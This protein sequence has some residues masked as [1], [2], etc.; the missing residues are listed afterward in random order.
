MS[1]RYTIS[2]VTVQG[3]ALDYKALSSQCSINHLWSPFF[4]SSCLSLSGIV[5]PS[6]HHCLH[7]IHC[8]ST[9][10]QSSLIQINFI[11]IISICLSIQI[12]SDCSY[13]TGISLILTLL[14]CST[15]IGPWDESIL[16]SPITNCSTWAFAYRSAPPPFHYLQCAARLYTVHITWMRGSTKRQVASQSLCKVTTL[17][18]VYK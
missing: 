18:F 6:L 1:L 12:H 2:P 16:T 7:S 15:S 11:I 13:H 4:L 3:H 9:S 17:A 14:I 8:C 5:S 10:I